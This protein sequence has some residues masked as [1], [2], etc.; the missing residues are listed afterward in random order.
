MKSDDPAYQGIHHA[1]MLV[2]DLPRALEFYCTV[3]G[4]RVD[5]NRPEM[6]YAG[7]WLEVGSQQIHLL[8]LPNPDPVANRPAHGGRDRHVCLAV[9]NLDVLCDR[10]DRHGVSYTRSRSGRKALFCRDPDANGLEFA[11]L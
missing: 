2:A 3:L 7:A 5:P 6:G 8:E 9:A 10:L 4:L 1:S 11:Q